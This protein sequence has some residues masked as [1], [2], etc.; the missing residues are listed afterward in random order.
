MG[1][2][3][4]VVRGAAVV[5]V[6]LLLALCGVWTRNYRQFRSKHTLGLL[7]FGVFLL[8][9]N[10]LAVYVFAFHPVLSVWFASPKKVPTLPGQAMM[11]L[12]VLETG[13][14]LFLTWVTWD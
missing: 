3:I 9:E 13:A 1:L 6:L 7:V 12:R 2:W 14:I 8:A 5:N 4:T 10:A 11:T